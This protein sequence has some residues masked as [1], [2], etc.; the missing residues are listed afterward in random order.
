[1]DQIPVVTVY[2]AIWQVLLAQDVSTESRRVLKASDT[3]ESL[4]AQTLHCDVSTDN[5]TLKVLLVVS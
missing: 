2:T 4:S 5:G 3:V 1:M